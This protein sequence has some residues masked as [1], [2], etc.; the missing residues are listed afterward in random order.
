MTIPPPKKRE[1]VADGFI[2]CRSIES[3]ERKDVC[4]SPHPDGSGALDPVLQ[5][6][7]HR[8]V[9]PQF[10]I[11]QKQLRTN[12]GNANAPQL[13]LNSLSSDSRLKTRLLK[14]FVMIEDTIVKG[15]KPVR[16]SGSHYL[17]SA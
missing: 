5:E 8:K 2:P 13:L 12:L 7:S 10:Y 6:Q 11:N 1:Q 4:S 17:F 16:N 3:C 9:T 15:D 14:D